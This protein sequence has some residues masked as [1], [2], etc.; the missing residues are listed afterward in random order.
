MKKIKES[1]ILKEVREWKK[2]VSKDVKKLRGQALLDYYNEA[3]KK[4]R[5]RRAA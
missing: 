4:F 5:K 2:A 1:K 3:A